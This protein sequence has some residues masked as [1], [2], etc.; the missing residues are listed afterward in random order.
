MHS[1]GSAALAYLYRQ[2]DEACCRTGKGAS[3]GGPMVLLTIW[4]WLRI[5]VGRPIPMKEK[6]WDDHGNS[7]LRAPTWA[8]LWDNTEVFHGESEECYLRYTNQLDLLTPEKVEWEPYGTRG[9]VGTGVWFQADLNRKCMQEAHLWRIRASLIC[10]YAIEFHLPQRVMRQFG[11]FQ[12]TPPPYKDTSTALH[13]LDK[14]KQKR[15]KIG[16]HIIISIFRSAFNR[17][18]VWLG[19]VYRLYLQPSAFI[20]D[21]IVEDPYPAFDELSQLEY[22]RLVRSG[23]GANSAGVIRFVREEI[24]KHVDDATEALK[25]PPGKGSES[26]LREFVERTKRWGCGLGVLL[27]CRTAEVA[28]PVRSSSLEVTGTS[29]ANAELEDDLEVDQDGEG[30][31]EDEDDDETMAPR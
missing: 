26:A 23:R 4:S 7:R 13:G 30:E 17:Y 10:V 24:S 11:L 18:L 3:I 29:N 5:L 16:L 9:N 1:W 15:E 31:D 8:Y 6:P 12:E 21:D 28:S 25:H 2:L 22:N 14:I 19:G 27:G 20:S